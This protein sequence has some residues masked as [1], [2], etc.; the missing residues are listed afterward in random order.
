M[1]LPWSG[2]WPC[3]N[4]DEDYISPEPIFIIG[5]GITRLDPYC[6]LKPCFT[7]IYIWS[8]TILACIYLLKIENIYQD[9]YQLWLLLVIMI[10][11]LQLLMSQ[12]YR[13]WRVFAKPHSELILAN[14]PSVKKIL[15][16]AC[17]RVSI[18]KIGNWQTIWWSSITLSSFLIINVF[19]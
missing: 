8:T 9:G 19:F 5:S 15:Q 4:I 16:E 7:T 17:W 12:L 18:Y 1:K 11:L 13:C 6:Q 10:R 3:I 14:K 2:H